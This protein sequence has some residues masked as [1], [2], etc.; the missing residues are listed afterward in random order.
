M[1]EYPIDIDEFDTTE[2]DPFL[3][4]VVRH[5]LRK[6]KNRRRLRKLFRK[7]PKTRILRSIGIGRRRRRTRP[8][9]TLDKRYRR[10]IGRPFRN[11]MVS[12]SGTIK[13]PFRMPPIKFGNPV[14][15]DLERNRG[16]SKIGIRKPIFKGTPIMPGDPR[17]RT[18]PSV[19]IPNKRKKPKV[20]RDIVIPYKRRYG[21]RKRRSTPIMRRRTPKGTIPLMGEELPIVAE[22]M[23]ASNMEVM[24]RNEKEK[25]PEKRSD[26]RK[27]QNIIGVAV[28]GLV[29]TGFVMYK[30]K[31][32]IEANG[33]TS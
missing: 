23:S 1:I 4:H 13:K 33:R 14:H 3:H 2:Y 16:I 17:K 5:K 30:M 7:H 29:V 31:T 32:K 24:D 20:S 25:K 9:R 18:R 12:R 27:M 6:R 19:S 11:R 10:P 8:V 21:S 26:K 22:N 15:R 28:L